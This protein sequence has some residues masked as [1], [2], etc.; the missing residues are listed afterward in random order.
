[1]FP[2]MSVSVSVSSDTLWWSQIRSKF[3]GLSPS[4]E[5]SRLAMLSKGQTFLIGAGISRRA[6]EGL[7]AYR[8]RG[9][10]CTV[11]PLLSFGARSQVY[12]R[13]FAAT[14]PSQAADSRRTSMTTLHELEKSMFLNLRSSS[15]FISH[16]LKRG[17]S[18][19]ARPNSLKEM[20]HIDRV[21]LWSGSCR[22]GE[23]RVV[24][25][26][27]VY[28]PGG[29]GRVPRTAV[30]R[31]RLNRRV[32][33]EFELEMDEGRAGSAD[34]TRRPWRR[35]NKEMARFQHRRYPA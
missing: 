33:E 29:R 5:T 15:S 21:V 1:M 22:I 14:L 16:A 4:I 18:V 25:S 19:S 7:R 24:S 35:S 10:P 11:A 2:S 6:W 13:G 34:S 12:P 3:L 32:R 20:I 8:S 17:Q 31:S 9:S 26:M 28:H 27:V 23:E 30:A